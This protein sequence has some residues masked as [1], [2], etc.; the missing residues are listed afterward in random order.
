[1]EI[2]KTRPR[3]LEIASR[4]H[5]SLTFRPILSLSLAPTLGN[6]LSRLD[7]RST[8]SVQLRWRLDRLAK[9]ASPE[10]LSVFPSYCCLADDAAKFVDDRIGSAALALWPA[11]GSLIGFLPFSRRS[12]SCVDLAVTGSDRL[13]RTLL[14]QHIFRSRRC[15]VK[16]HAV[17]PLPFLQPLLL[18]V[19]LR[20]KPPDRLSGDE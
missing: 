19:M 2:T 6:N 7:S 11:G 9:I 10:F 17:G 1:M 13:G 20:G 5:Q 8:P 15:A 12:P 14:F 4:A 3:N 16:P 18:P